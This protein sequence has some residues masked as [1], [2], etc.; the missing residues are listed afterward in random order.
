MAVQ[1]WMQ[2][3]SGHGA[4]PTG[5]SIRHHRGASGPCL[6]WERRLCHAARGCWELFL[7]VC[8][9]NAGRALC[10]KRC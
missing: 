5:C 6:L 1:P 7:W 8:H 4:L 10:S 3:P 9:G 2:H